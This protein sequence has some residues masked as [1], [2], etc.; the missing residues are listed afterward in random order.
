[1]KLFTGMLSMMLEPEISPSRLIVNELPLLA[2][3]L[4]M[5]LMISWPAVLA[6]D[7]VQSA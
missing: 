1:M 7:L 6:L 5:M 4:G 2:V 3:R